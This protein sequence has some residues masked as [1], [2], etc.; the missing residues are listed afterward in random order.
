[1]AFVTVFT[2][3]AMIWVHQ[4]LSSFTA[5]YQPIDYSNNTFEYPTLDRIHGAP[6]F[7]TLTRLKK[8]LQANAQS[9]TSELGGG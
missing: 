4:N 1:M 6:M 9:N 8:Q 7:T 3:G 2:T 5:L